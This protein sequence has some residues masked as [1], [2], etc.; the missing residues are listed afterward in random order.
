MDKSYVS[1]EKKQCIICGE[2]YESGSLLFDKT[3]RATF[4]KYTVTGMG[5]CPEH[6]ALHDQGYVA[7]VVVAN[8][9][10]STK[11]K[12]SEVD[13][14]G[15][16]AHMSRP[17]ARAFLDAEFPDDE[18]LCFIDQGVFDVLANMHATLE[19]TPKVEETQQGP[20]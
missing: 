15:D 5:L 8:I 2:T 10:G 9:G 14:T 3:L 20:P 1:I 17:A 4:E 18:P 16:V 11:L 19:P 13:R 7:M 6:Q 12:P